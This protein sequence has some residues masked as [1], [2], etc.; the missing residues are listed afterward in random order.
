MASTGLLH[1]HTN[2]SIQ[3]RTRRLSKW[4]RAIPLYVMLL[5][6]I[7][8]FM[9]LT[10][11]PLVHSVL[12][13]MQDFNLI[14]TRPFVGIENFR[15]VL[16]D[17][18]FWVDFRNTLV[19]GVSMLGIGF[20][21]PII[22][23]LSLNELVQR[24]LKRS[25]QMIIYLPHLFSWVVV[26][27][28]WIQ[29]LNPDGGLVNAVLNALGMSSI[30]FMSDPN[31]ARWVIILV[32]VWKDVGFNCVIYLAAL[33]GINPE[34]YAS[35]Q[36]DGANCWQE[37]WYVTMPCLARTMQIVG[38]LSIMGVLRMFDQIYVMRNAVIEPTVNV[39]MT[40]VYDQGFTQMNIG[41]ATASALIILV[42]TLLLT[43]FTR[44]LVRY[45]TI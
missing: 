18:N 37:T 15:N 32:S 29:L 17:P 40:Y 42:F 20:V 16:T 10:Y 31:V 33:V 4:K 12:I 8:Y 28:L 9:A 11:Y 39:L 38:L 45:D 44:R 27:G 2:T 30:Q 1:Q 22:I 6:T 24:W 43:V 23:A 7:A 25:L 14:G 21:A 41:Q 19:L 36:V 34:L 26:G 13:S 3:Q 5:P 35:A